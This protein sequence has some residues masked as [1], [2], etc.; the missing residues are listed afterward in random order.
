MKWV[1]GRHD[2][3]DGWTTLGE[4]EGSSP[5]TALE[6]WIDER[7]GAHVGEYGVRVEDRWQLFGYGT[8]GVVRPIF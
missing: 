2:E 7:E 3:S 1:I 5:R 8:D 6:H 4:G